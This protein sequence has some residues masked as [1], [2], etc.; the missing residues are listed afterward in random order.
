MAEEKYKKVDTIELVIPSSVYHVGDE[1]LI[2]TLITLLEDALKYLNETQDDNNAAVVKIKHHFDLISDYIIQDAGSNKYNR[3]CLLMYYDKVKSLSDQIRKHPKLA[4]DTTKSLEYMAINIYNIN[5][6][7]HNYG[8][9]ILLS[10]RIDSTRITNNTDDWQKVFDAYNDQ[11]HKG[12]IEIYQQTWDG[13]KTQV[14]KGTLASFLLL[15]LFVVELDAETKST[16]PL[17][18]KIAQVQNTRIFFNRNFTMESIRN[19]INSKRAIQYYHFLFQSL[20][21][22]YSRGEFEKLPDIDFDDKILDEEKLKDPDALMKLPSNLDNL[23]GQ[24]ENQSN[25]L[26]RNDSRSE[27]T[28]GNMGATNS[29][30]QRLPT[31]FKPNDYSFNL[32]DKLTGNFTDL[33]DSWTSWGGIWGKDDY[34]KVKG[35]QGWINNIYAKI[36][37]LIDRINKLINYLSDLLTSIMNMLNKLIAAIQKLLDKLKALACKLKQLMCILGALMNFQEA[38]LKPL[39]ENVKKTYGEAMDVVGRV[40]TTTQKVIDTTEKT[41][42]NQAWDEGKNI[43]AGK[44]QEVAKAMNVPYSDQFF[45]DWSGAID[46]CKETF[47]KRDSTLY[48]NMTQDLKE[49]VNDSFEEVIGNPLTNYSN[50][51]CPPIN[52][53]LPELN[54]PDLGDF[55]SLPDFKF[56]GLDFDLDC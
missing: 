28:S 10:K 16:K 27:F 37:A 25:I 14:S 47:M 39:M 56:D 55:G 49:Y 4:P 42:K 38:I 13:Y 23:L 45:Q 15:W 17:I 31:I 2:Y 40:I 29:M 5:E 11:I 44:A 18:E 8:D 7:A 36:Q 52:I 48:K 34:D 43:L 1:E 3:A 54:L 24:I 30:L 32:T 12:I 50:A 46:K 33:N 51:N 26:E 21:N 9:Y 20:L 53:K 22:L 19:I 41:M 35:L 6:Y